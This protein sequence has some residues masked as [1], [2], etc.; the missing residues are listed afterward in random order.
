MKM[1]AVNYSEFRGNLKSYLDKSIENHEPI[2]VT[3]KTGNMVVMSLEDYNSIM[4]T[5]YLLR[6][7]ANAEHL[8]KSIEQLETGK[9]I[10][11]SLEELEECE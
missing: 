4:E 10:E 11:K 9:G 6:S 5:N 3:R 2:I 1:E 7:K 8:L